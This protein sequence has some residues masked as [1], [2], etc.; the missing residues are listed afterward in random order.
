MTTRT[1]TAIFEEHEDWWVAYVEELP[2][3]NAQGE[4]LEEAKA[5]LAEA[6]VMV[7][8][9]NRELAERERR[10]RPVIR[11]EFPVAFAA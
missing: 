3:A 11:E 8:E 1:F 9:A 10:G 7:L 4:T 5:N 6:V 2:G